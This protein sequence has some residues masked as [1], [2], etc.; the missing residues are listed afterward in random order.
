MQVVHSATGRIPQDLLYGEPAP[1]L[2][3]IRTFFCQAFYQRPVNKLKTTEKRSRSVI[4]L[5]HDVG[6]VYNVCFDPTGNAK[7]IPT[8]HVRVAEDQFSAQVD[9]FKQ[10]RSTEIKDSGS[11]DDAYCT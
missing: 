5:T 6:G 9:H 2:H 1:Y 4:C 11:K 3:H 8:K 10:H 7:V